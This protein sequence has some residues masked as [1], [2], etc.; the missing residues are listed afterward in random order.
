MKLTPGVRGAANCY[1][2]FIFIPITS[3]RSA[4]KCLYHLAKA[5]RARKSWD[6]YLLASEDSQIYPLLVRFNL[7]NLDPHN[8]AKLRIITE[9]SKKCAD[10]L[11]LAI[12]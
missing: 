6:A 4:A 3:D 10:P 7:Q 5:P 11:R 2:F 1:N 12:L 9:R 8:S